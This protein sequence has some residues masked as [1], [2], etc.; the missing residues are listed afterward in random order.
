MEA[1]YGGHSDHHG[2]A[3][4]GGG[5]GGGTG[6]RPGAAGRLHRGDRGARQ[7]HRGGGGADRCQWAIDHSGADQCAHARPWRVGQGHR[8]SLVAGPAAERRHLDQRGPHRRGPLSFDAAVRGGNAA[9]GLH[10]LLRPAGDAADA[11]GGGVARGGARLRR[12][13]HARGGVADDRRSQLLPGDS[14]IA[15]SVPAGTARRRRDAAHRFGRGDPGAH[16]CRGR[17]VAVSARPHPAGYRADDPAAL[18]G[19]V[20][21]RRAATSRRSS[22]CRCR[23]IWRNR[24]CSGLGRSFVTA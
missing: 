12:C 16:S 22:A 7:F 18:L 9:Q 20:H 1:D 19:R 24:R 10:R 2:R 6:G 3:G 23:R 5:G 17:G 4:A 14:G 21:D 15:G 8:R 11:V 13:G